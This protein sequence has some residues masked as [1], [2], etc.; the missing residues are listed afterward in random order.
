MEVSILDSSQSHESFLVEFDAV[1]VLL[2]GVEQKSGK[3]SQVSRTI[4]GCMI[5]V[6]GGPLF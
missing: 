6:A 4:Y 5:P 3:L 1:D 2:R